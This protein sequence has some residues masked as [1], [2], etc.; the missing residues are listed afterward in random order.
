M[1]VIAY[2]FV[3]RNLHHQRNFCEANRLS[4]RSCA[5]NILMLCNVKG[6][7]RNVPLYI[8]IVRNKNKI[9]LSSAQ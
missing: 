3:G 1:L 9:I 6:V 5:P 8:A 2:A 4:L 7:L